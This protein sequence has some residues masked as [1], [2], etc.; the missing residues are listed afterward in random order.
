MLFIKIIFL[1]EP[2]E[3]LWLQFTGMCKIQYSESPID[4]A[5]TPVADTASGINAFDLGAANSAD[6]GQVSIN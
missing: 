6:R 2:Q 3:I 4:S 5:A 1:I